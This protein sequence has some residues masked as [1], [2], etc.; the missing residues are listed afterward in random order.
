MWSENIEATHRCLRVQ[1]YVV[2]MR[3]GSGC[4]LRVHLKANVHGRIGVPKGD[5]VF[6]VTRISKNKHETLC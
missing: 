2:R 4:L 6:R 3:D 1:T 5:S